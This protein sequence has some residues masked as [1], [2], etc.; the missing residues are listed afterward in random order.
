MCIFINLMWLAKV[1]SSMCDLYVYVLIAIMV[2]ALDFQREW[3]NF[4]L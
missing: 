4:C 3:V 1:C 2:Y